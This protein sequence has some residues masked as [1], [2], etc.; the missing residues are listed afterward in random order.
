MLSKPW[1]LVGLTHRKGGGWSKNYVP[2]MNNKIP[3]EDI[4]NEFKEFYATR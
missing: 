4:V 1:K 3:F 2:N